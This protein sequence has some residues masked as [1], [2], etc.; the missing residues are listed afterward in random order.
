MKKTALVTGGSRGIGRA[1]CIQLARQGYDVAFC[2]QSNSDAALA[3]SNELAQLG[4]R[5]YASR[6]DVSQMA[7]AKRF[8]TAAQAELGDIEVLV[9]CAGIIND[10]PLV[11]LSEEAWHAVIDTNLTGTYNFC[12]LAAFAFMKMKR[13]SI[14]N[15]SSIAGVTGNA[16]QTN[17]AASKAGINGFTKALS[18]E[19]GPFGVRV[20]SL[21]PGFIDTDMTGHL[22]EAIEKK[23]LE[24]IS[25]RRMGRADEVAHLAG[26]LAGDNASY[27]T[28]QVIQVDGG[29]AL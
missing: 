8:F 11:S 7:D 9:N 20:N 29:I 10:A 6:C 14:I 16:G 27:I 19:L 21:A 26:F 5:S 18:K 4:V 17:Y 2:Y 22:H 13:G 24:K 12:K 23:M 1:I 25:L 15:V 28:G 3:V